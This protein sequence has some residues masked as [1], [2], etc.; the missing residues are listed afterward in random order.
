MHLLIRFPTLLLA[1]CAL[2]GCSAQSF[3]ESM[4]A[5]MDAHGV[6][7]MSAL[8]ICGGNITEAYHGGLRNL[9]NDWPVTSETRYRVASV[10]KSIT[11]MGCMKLVESGALDLDADASGYLPFALSNP[12]HPEAAI[13]LRM[14]L[15]HTSSIQD[16]DGYSP[17]LPA[18]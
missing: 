7:G 16:G 9:E 8:V 10:S 17:F 11:A 1:L 3:S 14:L 13:T 15:S 5:T 2:P 4:D 18:T 12:N 6:M